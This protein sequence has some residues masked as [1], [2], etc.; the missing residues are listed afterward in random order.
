MTEHATS[1]RN[2][3]R[4][5]KAHRLTA[6]AKQPPSVAVVIPMHNEEEAVDGLLDDIV[7]AVHAMSPFEIIAV[8]DGSTDATWQ[9]LQHACARHTQLRLLRHT[10]ADGQS[11]AVHSGVSDEQQTLS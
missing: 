7:A 2:A 1:S 9:R 11:A 5:P 6:G 3:E 8:D 4:S 10:N